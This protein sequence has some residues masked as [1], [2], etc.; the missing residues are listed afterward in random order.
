MSEIA[1][2][3]DNVSFSPNIFTPYPGIP[4]WPELRR[5][6][7]AE[8][9]SLEAWSDLALGANVLPWLHGK[10]YSNVKRGMSFLLLNNDIIK[11]R[12]KATLSRRRRLLL[13]ALQQPLRW[14]MR[15]QFFRLPL[16]LWL[17][18]ERKLTRRS[19]L[20]GQRLAKAGRA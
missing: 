14:R 18:K 17:L 7:V 12:R 2:R 20:T 11:A 16:E 13:R 10:T 1:Q 6:G 4:I 3:F 8:P 15:H 19:L 9:D 5:L